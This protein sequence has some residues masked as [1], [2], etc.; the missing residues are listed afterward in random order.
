MK[1]K[2]LLTFISLNIIFNGYSQDIE[3]YKKVQLGETESLTLNSV[4]GTKFSSGGKQTRN[5]FA[6]NIPPMTEFIIINVKVDNSNAEYDAEVSKNMMQNLMASK[7]GPSTK[8]IGGAALLALSPPKTGYKCDFYMFPNK[9]NYDAFFKL[10][11]ITNYSYEP[12]QCY[13]Y[14]SPYQRLNYESFNIVVDVKNLVDKNTLYLAFRNNDND[15][16]IKVFVN[17]F[18]L[19]GNG[20]TKDV[21]DEIYKKLYDNLKSKGFSNEDE[22]KETCSCFIVSVTKKYDLEEFKA[23][24][25]FE[26][27]KVVEELIKGCNSELATSDTKSKATTYGNLGWKSF[28]KGDYDK[29]LE[30][31][32]KALA[33]DNSLTYIYF[34]IA[35]VHLI[36]NEKEAIDKYIDAV[37]RAKKAIAP[38]KIIQSALDDILNYEKINGVLANSSDV[39]DVLSA[40][41]K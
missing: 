7:A 39:K 18:A 13:P 11:I 8:L 3:T 19:I 25:E 24:P 12:N 28:E 22:L 27:N 33:I 38:V 21:R 37:Q 10:G 34:N 41:I 6:E 40:E 35:L 14:S 30:Y 36:K 26:R 15:N 29:C 16:A 31:S 20:W 5:G 1:K 23:L 32:Q 17:V 2:L 4:L 9:T